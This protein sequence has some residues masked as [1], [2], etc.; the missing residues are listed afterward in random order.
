MIFT[1]HDYGAIKNRY[2]GKCPKCHGMEPLREF[3]LNLLQPEMDWNLIENLGL[4]RPLPEA[5]NPKLTGSGEFLCGHEIEYGEVCYV[6]HTNRDSL[7]LY[8][9]QQ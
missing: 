6:I 9:V 1:I 5:S 3:T 4:G 8:G 2:Y 7:E